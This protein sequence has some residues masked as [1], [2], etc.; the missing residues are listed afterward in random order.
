MT[1]NIFYFFA[2]SIF[3]LASNSD[4][5]WIPYCT[6]L[7]NDVTVIYKPIAPAVEY[8][9]DA[10]IT[11][12]NIFIN[13]IIL[14][15]SGIVAPGTCGVVGLTI[16]VSFICKNVNTEAITDNTIL[17]VANKSIPRNS[18]LIPSRL[19]YCDPNPY[20]KLYN[21]SGGIVLAATCLIT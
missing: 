8:T 3:H 1:N 14:F 20:K 12:K 2:N 18:V 9:N 4:L 19:K 7:N 11:T 10:I 16:V 13:H 21:H 6:T 17:P 5:Y 15:M